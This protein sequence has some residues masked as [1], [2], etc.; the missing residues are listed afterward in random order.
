MILCFVWCCQS[1]HADQEISQNA[2]QIS[3]ADSL[4][5][6]DPKAAESIY[7]VVLRDSSA[8]SR[9]DNVNALLGL[10]SVYSNRGAFD[11]ATT[12]LNK[13][14]D[15]AES[16]NDTVLIMTCLLGKGNI[17]L[18]LGDHTQSEYSY[19]KG[20]AL[21]MR[22]KNSD[23]QNRFFLG[24]GNEQL[25]RGDYPAAGKT[26]TE[27]MK[28]AE[29]AGDEKNL[30][31][32]L[33]NMSITLKLTGE[34]REAIKYS[35]RSLQIRKK[36]NLLHDYASGLQNLGVI[37]R[38]LDKNDSALI[39]YRQ[40]NAIFQN[41][42]DS[43]SIVR[44]RYNIGI[45]LKNQKKFR[46]A[47]AEMKSILQFCQ[48][49]NITEGQIYALSAL[50]SI[51][52][53]TSRAGEALVAIDS[54]V[55][56]ARRFRLSANLSLLL[57]RQHEI[58]ARLGHYKEAYQAALASRILSDSLLSLE[59]QKAI[60]TLKTRYE[61]ERKEVENVLLKKEIEVKRTQVWLLWI[62]VILATSIFALLLLL[63]YLRSQRI[64]QQKLLAEEKSIR[65]EQEKRNKE[66][67]LVFQSLVQTDLIQL[68]RSFKE[69][70]LPFKL[71]LPRKNQQDEFE[72]VLNGLTRDA[73]KDPLAEFELLFT[74]LHA[75]F[76]ENIL[77]ICPDL[78]KTEL[79]VCAMIRLNLSTKDIARLTNI[80]MNSI[81]MTRYHIRKKLNLE[82]G[83]NLAAFLMTV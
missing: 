59:K 78:T 2:R 80:N 74:Q 30:A 51:F 16:M 31:L 28:I 63:L 26:F 58:L 72:Q 27:A 39:F 17:T 69:K 33:E 45:I 49:K 3:H 32:A 20:L 68:N 61:T 75:S 67:E 73:N 70:L 41:L 66:Q 77:R 19:K 42:N 52:D 13:A 65:M 7:R 83:E 23:F 82:Q 8:N 55:S 76:S 71:K 46:E 6:F 54:S 38:N 48:Q 24:L 57:D 35:N 34:F 47:E 53:Q 10:S 29:K 43:V 50:A 9:S 18:D 36:L 79:H 12:F 21:A 4:I 11:S 22:T 60:A 62:G 1:H 25:D 15:M 64:R 37:Y 14:S 56:K 81:E 5:Q 44:V 40:A